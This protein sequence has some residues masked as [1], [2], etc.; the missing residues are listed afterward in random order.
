[1]PWV[2]DEIVQAEVD[3]LKRLRA[4]VDEMPP[5]KVTL[6]GDSVLDKYVHGWANRLNATAPVPAV[7]VTSSEAFAGAAAHVARGLMSLGMIPNLF[8]II[9]GD[10]SGQILASNLKREGIDTSGLRVVAN[11]QTV[12]KTR[13]YGA[14]ESLIE[15]NQLLL[16]IDEEP[17]EEMPP[18]VSQRLT[19]TALASLSDADVLVLSDYNKGAITDAGAQ[20]LISAAKGN[21]IP[22]ICDPKLT[23][24]NRTEGATCVLFEIR[25]LEL[26]RRR[27]GLASSAETARDLISKYNWEALVVLGGVQGLWLYTADAE[28]HI[29]CLLDD[30]RQ[31]IGLHDAAAVAMAAALSQGASL[32][33]AATLAHAA[34]E[35]I[36]GAEEGQEVLDRRTLSASMDERAW[37]M[38]VSDR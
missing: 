18:A 21:G 9:G 22:I 23:G 29:P 19:V 28:H 1:M 16:Q 5:K 10:E 17:Q 27:L 14:R 20:Q 3:R 34:C 11:R 37:Q 31:I 15:Q 2:L 6:V 33:D 38:Q 26:T 24:L 30:A 35:T 36:L 8:S 4:M 32:H 25:G 13:I 12:V 7:K